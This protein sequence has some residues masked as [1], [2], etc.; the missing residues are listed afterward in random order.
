MRIVAALFLSLAISAS[1]AETRFLEG[2]AGRASSGDSFTLMLHDGGIARIHLAGADAPERGQPYWRL[3]RGH[4]VQLLEPA[5]VSAHCYM[6][7]RDRRD[8]CR[9]YVQG[10][11]VALEQVEAGYAWWF[12]EFANDQTEQE[13]IEYE[14][15][16]NHAR[17]ARRG[18]WQ[19]LNPEAPWAYRKRLRASR[20][21]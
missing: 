16:E 13:R 18:L 21:K 8:V 7:D 12:R 6:K 14:H 1:A 17:A 19:E 4:L 10:R 2:S 20:T 11:D 5:P 9:V 15:A 3:S